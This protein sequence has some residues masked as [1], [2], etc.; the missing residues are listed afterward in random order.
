MLF[1]PTVERIVLPSGEMVVPF[2][3]SGMNCEAHFI[4]HSFNVSGF[5]IFKSVNSQKQHGIYAI[6]NFSFKH[7][8]THAFSAQ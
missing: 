2:L 5:T 6:W 1:L 3:F 4:I 8:F 7:S